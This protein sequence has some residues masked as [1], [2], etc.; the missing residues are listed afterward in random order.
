MVK[1]LFGGIVLVIGIY[2]S[3]L[4][5][6]SV[7]RELRRRTH[8]QLIYFG[9][10]AH[11]P[12]GEKT[13]DQLEGYFWN[14]VGFFQEK[15]CQGVVVACN[16]SSALVLPRVHGKIQLP[17]FG[18]IE[19]AVQAALAVSK[20]RVGVLA[21]RGTV[22][23]G[24]YQQAFRQA[25]PQGQVFVKSAP[26]LVPLVE[27]GQI[28]SQTTR[29][30]LQEYLEPL[31]AKKIDTLLLGCTHYPFLQ[32]LLEDLVGSDVT[33]VDPA[34]TVARQLQASLP[35]HGKG[36]EESSRQTEFWVSSEPHRFREMA[37]LLLKEK[38]P[39]VGF[40]HMS[41]ERA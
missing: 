16:T 19:S 17:V 34:P 38:L 30:A 23:S 28:T 22:A 24:V 31:L 9:D 29:Q 5:G 6:L 35:N 39:P 20:G 40:H 33:I 8:A 21:T 13:P 37:E 18:I 1:C 2:D 15:G 32:E 26:R 14:I 11:V 10:T 41:G 25:S 4:G 3:G 36:Q 27:Q 12:Y 7:W